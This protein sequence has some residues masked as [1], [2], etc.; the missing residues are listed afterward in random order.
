MSPFEPLVLYMKGPSPNPWKVAI[1]LEELGL[2]W[3]SVRVKETELKKEPF[4]SLNPNGKV[5]VLTDP[6]TGIVLWEV[7]GSCLRC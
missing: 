5:P 4:L 6:N 1:I 2:P 3:S 7:S